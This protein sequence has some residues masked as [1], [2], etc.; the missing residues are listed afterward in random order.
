MSDALPGASRSGVENQS[1]IVRRASGGRYD[2]ACMA[3]E[4]GPMPVAA[5]GEVVVKV[6]QLSLDPSN[7]NWLKLDPVLQYLPV[8]LGGPM[9][10]MGVGVVR[11]SRSDKFAAG[12]TVIGMIPWHRFAAADPAYLERALPESVMPFEHQL[13]LLAHVG[14]AATTGLLGVC[15]VRA[16]DKVL[17]SGA[18]GATGAL[19][20]QIAK[21]LGCYTV[22]VAGSEEKCRFLK[23]DLQLDA[24]INYRSE[25]L[26]PAVKRLFPEGV[27][28][29]FDNVG[30]ELLDVVLGNMAV[31]CR[32]AICGAMSQYDIADGSRLYGIRNL[33]LL[34]FRR[35]LMQGFIA[36]QFPERNAEFRALLLDLYRQGKLRA[37]I[38]FVDGF[39]CMAQAL[40]MLLSG[41]NVGKLI[42]RMGYGL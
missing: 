24:A 34:V 35:G 17:I 12:D 25:A 7:I 42:A 16:T 41:E 29:F 9:I 15:K 39:E 33:P 8:V 23:E 3:L 5:E 6:R 30:G 14:M 10:G 27:D 18:A 28:V 1:W 20:A 31:G 32:I 2:P 40:K 26:E 37:Q 22:G 4:P 13:A 21:A 11:E 19:A 38:H 36:G